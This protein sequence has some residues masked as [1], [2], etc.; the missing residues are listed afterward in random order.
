MSSHA[1]GGAVS[2]ASSW[3]F[4]GGAAAAAVVRSIAPM[5]TVS[6]TDMDADGDG[7][8]KMMVSAAAAVTSAASAG[9]RRVGA[10]DMFEVIMDSKSARLEHGDR[11]IEVRSSSTGNEY[12]YDRAAAPC[13][14][15]LSVS[16]ELALTPSDR[17]LTGDQL[18]AAAADLI[19]AFVQHKYAD[20]L[21][22]K[23]YDSDSCVICLEDR[24]DVCFVSCGHICTHRKCSES[25]DKCPV[26][27]AEIAARLQPRPQISSSPSAP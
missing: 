23:T 2:T 13:V 18:N 16:N 19:A 1:F 4:G 27:R 26:C 5:S 20:F 11:R 25:L 17:R 6:A 7:D 12:A 14:L 21:A 22:K 8:M 9:P 24:P 15:G 10:R 3:S